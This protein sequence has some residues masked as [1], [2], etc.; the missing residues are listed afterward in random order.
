M[1][2]SAYKH[3]LTTEQILHA[4]ELPVRSFD[5]DEGF[6]MLIGAD[7]TGALLE[8]GVITA[9]DGGPVIV[10]AQEARPKFLR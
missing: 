1:A 10:H 6:V 3:E 9:D 8:V 7:P 5:L 4:F 2:N